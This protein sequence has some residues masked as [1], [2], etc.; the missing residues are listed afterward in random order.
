VK[1]LAA[2]ALL[3]AALAAPARAEPR[4]AVEPQSYD[5]GRVRPGKLFRQSFTLG[6]Y[7]SSTLALASALG[8]C[9]CLRIEGPERRTLEPGESTKLVVVFA[10]R[11][12][13]GR[14]ERKLTL[15]S[16]DPER[17]LLEVPI[18]ATVVASK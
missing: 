11:R 16:N 17:P 7:G 13:R 12:Y 8:D 14:V 4:L 5:F 15:R 10:S 6:N 18:A 1:A 2:A 9:E 3:L